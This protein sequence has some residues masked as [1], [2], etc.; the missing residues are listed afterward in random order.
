LVTAHY[1]IRRLAASTIDPL[2]VFTT[3]AHVLS[4]NSPVMAKFIDQLLTPAFSAD[5]SAEDKQRAHQPIFAVHI[6]QRPSHLHIYI[7]LLSSTFYRGTPL[8][9]LSSF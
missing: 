9:R 7:R 6:I 8:P 5:I 2:K 1:C 4:L 3:I